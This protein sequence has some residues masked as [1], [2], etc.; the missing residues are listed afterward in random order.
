MSN[1][2]YNN[3]ISL[4]TEGRLVGIETADLAGGITAGIEQAISNKLK[5]LYVG[6][7]VVFKTAEPWNYQTAASEGGIEAFAKYAPFVF[8]KYAPPVP[9][10]RE[11]DGD[12]KQVLQFAVILGTESKQKGVAR[13]GSSSKLGISKIRDLVIAALDNWHPGE[14]FECDPLFYS[15][16][17]VQLDMPNRH[18]LIMYFKANMI[19]N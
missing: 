7:S 3:I 12:L 13:I 10:G 8:A 9:A 17:E 18:A 14:G 16:E 11:G 6:D 5:T 15:D 2:I 4:T 1:L 19:T